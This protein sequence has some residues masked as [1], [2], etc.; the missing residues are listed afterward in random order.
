MISTFYP[1]AHVLHFYCNPC[2]R[3]TQTQAVAASLATRCVSRW[4]AQR[5][6]SSAASSAPQARWAG[7]TAVH[8]YAQGEW[9]FG[10]WWQLLCDLSWT[11]PMCLIMIFCTNIHP[12]NRGT[13]WLSGWMPT[14][15]AI[16]C[17]LLC[18]AMHAEGLLFR[19]VCSVFCA[20]MRSV[21]LL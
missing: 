7:R 14:I 16:F 19:Q 10:R 15:L 1:V 17:A 12:L 18:A 2:T 21:Y 13:G 5:W 11:L 6:A 4:L 20:V 3:C 9:W 8:T